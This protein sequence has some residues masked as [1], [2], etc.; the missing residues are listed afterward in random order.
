MTIKIYKFKIIL[1]KLVKCNRLNKL[2]PGTKM[3]LDLIYPSKIQ[4][5]K[6]DFSSFKTFHP[7]VDHNHCERHSSSGSS[8]NKLTI[9][10]ISQSSSELKSFLSMT[11]FLFPLHDSVEYSLKEVEDFCEQIPNLL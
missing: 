6:R 8:T 3:D 11:T 10:R 5:V 9:S 2:L 4:K 7:L 1:K